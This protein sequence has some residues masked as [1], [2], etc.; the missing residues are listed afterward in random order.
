MKRIRLITAACLLAASFPAAGQDGVRDFRQVIENAPGLFLSNPAFLDAIQGQIALVT[1]DARK[2]NGGVIP[3][4]ES[5]DSYRAGASAEAYKRI[6]GKLSFHGKL[7]WHYS[8]GKDMGGQILMDPSYNPVNFLEST[9]ETMGRKH[10][11]SYTLEGGLSYNFGKRWAIGVKLDYQAADQTKVKDP[12]FSNIWMD[13][14][15]HSGVSFRPSEKWLFGLS[16]QYRNTLE[17]VKGGVYGTTDRQYFVATD[18]GAFLGTVSQLDGDYNA[19]PVSSFRPMFNRFWG[20]SIQAVMN[21]KFASELW[22]LARN[23]YYGRKSS[24]TAT[25]FEFNGFQIGYKSKLLIPGANQL[26]KLNWSIGM[27]MLTNRENK[28]RYVTPAGMNT[29]VEYLGQDIVLKRT[30]AR[31]RIAYVWE[32]GLD[33]FLPS[34]ILGASME[35]QLQSQQANLFPYTRAQRV[36]SAKADVYAT[37]NLR[38]GT[39]LFTLEI[40]LLGE[41]GGG[42]P[43][44]DQVDP[45]ATSSSIKSFDSYLYRQY[46]YETA[47]RAGVRIAFRWTFLS[48]GKL[49]PYIQMADEYLH[50]VSHPEYLKG[51][52]RNSAL[53]SIGCN[54]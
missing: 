7:D 24:T 30:Q 44:E 17:Q 12:R 48:G 15:L 49:V 9:E 1:L 31:A 23:G 26:H 20:G 2:D 35:S 34:F 8:S 10:R 22:M 41:G 43:L 45:S 53:L 47:P 36:L 6:S 3:L 18:K 4:T 32:K 14:R 27:E 42:T 25:F 13:I 33:G 54:F 52:G 51:S 5:A 11:E 29:I 46:E 19:I 38:A 37:K 50:L 16:F 28:F 40:H 21:G 39:S